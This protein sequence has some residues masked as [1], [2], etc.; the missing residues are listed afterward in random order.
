MVPSLIHRIEEQWGNLLKQIPPPYKPLLKPALGVLSLL[1]IG[2]LF[3]A[4]RP[5]PAR[6]AVL[7]D[8]ELMGWVEDRR[9]LEGALLLLQEE[10]ETS[11]GPGLELAAALDFEK[12]TGRDLKCE[13]PDQL[14]QRLGGKLA[15]TLP[16]ALIVVDGDP[17]TALKQET[18]AQ[19]VLEAVREQYL[20]REE[21]TILEEMVIGEMVEVVPGRVPTEELCSCDEALRI[22]LRGTDEI[23][24]HRVVKGESLWSIA[25][26][27]DLTVDDLKAANMDLETEVLQIGQELDLVVPKPYLTVQTREKTTFTQSIPYPTRTLKDANLYIYERKVQKPGLAG[28]KEVTWEIVRENGQEVKRELLGER[29]LEEPITQVVALGT[30]MPEARGTGT[31]SWPMSRGSITS[32]YGMRRGRMH[33]GVDIAA[34][35]GSPITAADSGVVTMAEWYGGYGRTVIV[36]HGNGTSTLYGHCSESLVRVGSKVSKGQLIARVGSTGRSTGAHLHFEVRENGRARD[37]MSYFK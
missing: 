2:V 9:E 21:D 35:T 23:I 22:L 10:K 30:K 18:E 17:V 15:Y 3:I 33:S 19:Q 8:G 20:P 4:F 14:A 16:A 7:L 37:P 28:S 6:W 29:L 1:L 24:T 13:D 32:R 36:D 26:N 34:P 27:F 12:V 11:Y 31:L 5:S 25:R